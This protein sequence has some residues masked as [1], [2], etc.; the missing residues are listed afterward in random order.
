M[1]TKGSFLAVKAPSTILSRRA[2]LLKTTTFSEGSAFQ[3]W[4]IIASSLVT[5]MEKL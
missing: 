5:F 1:L 2:Q 3:A 4:P